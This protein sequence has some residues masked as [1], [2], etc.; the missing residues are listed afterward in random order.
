VSD[1]GQLFDINAVHS[2]SYRMTSVDADG[3]TT[4][5][6]FAIAHNDTTYGGVPARH[7]SMSFDAPATASAGVGQVSVDIYTRKSDNS[8]LGG[9]MKMVVNG[10]TLLDMD[11][12]PGEAATYTSNDVLASGGASGNTQL[13]E[14]G[15]DTV[16][17][18]SKTYTCTR[19]G[20]TT[21]G[22]AYTVWHTAQAPMPVKMQWIEKGS[23]NTVELLSWS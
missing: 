16:T 10:Q 14:Q 23:F 15:T 6:N 7:L 19:Y 9:H 21:D 20:Y 2:Y 1:A 18:D 4:V 11:I 17:I 22:I 8:T 12:P 13:T 3:Q 5:A